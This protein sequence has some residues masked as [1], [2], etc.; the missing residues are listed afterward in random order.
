[1]IVILS[2][3]RPSIMAVWSRVV[4][5]ALAA[6]LVALLVALAA[7]WGH[8]SG[9]LDTGGSV[10]GFVLIVEAAGVLGLAAVLGRAL[11][12]GPR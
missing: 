7:E 3:M 11:R 9:T 10:L 1:M 4:G 2:Y 5:V 6:A 12:A 8:I